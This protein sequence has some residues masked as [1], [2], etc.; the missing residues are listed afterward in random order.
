MKLYPIVARLASAAPFF[1]RSLAL[2]AVLFGLAGTGQP[3]RAQQASP[4]S[5]TS[6]DAESIR[7]RIDNVAQ[8]P[9]RVQVLNLSSGQMLFDESYTA[10]A[11]GKRFSFRNLP[12]GRYALLLKAAGTQYRYVMQV[13]AGPV[14]PVLT[15]RTIRVQGEQLL[16]AAR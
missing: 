11:Y 1:S 10:P 7:V 16:T 12:A 8:L 3:A 15:L 2:G 6:P 5:V 4:V 9:G 13:Q 14:G